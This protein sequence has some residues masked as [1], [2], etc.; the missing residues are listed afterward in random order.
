MSL[1]PVSGKSERR[2]IRE[3][4]GERAVIEGLFAEGVPRKSCRN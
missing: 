1:R 4:H 3:H 2:R